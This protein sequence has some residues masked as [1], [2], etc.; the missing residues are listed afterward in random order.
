MELKDIAAVAGKPGLYKVVKPARTG[1]LLE[2]LDGKG[3][4][5]VT[6]P[7][8]RVSLLS[9]ISMYSVDHEVTLPLCDLFRKIKAEFGDDPG[10]DAK[11]DKE[12]L[13][14]FMAHIAPNYD[15]TRVYASD[16]RKL[17]TWYLVVLQ[18]APEVLA[19][20]VEAEKPEEKDEKKEAE[21]A[22]AAPA[23][24][25]APVKKTP[26]AKKKAG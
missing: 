2:S 22:P 15:A 23:S 17:V 10:V 8:Q 5:L 6:G 3:A 19:A 18:A 25:E 4:R 20:P 11:S 1:L 14:A 7:T 9:E 16:I 21:S 13:E 12:E 26:K 24:P